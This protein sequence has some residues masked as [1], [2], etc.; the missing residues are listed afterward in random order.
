VQRYTYAGIE[1]LA[2]VSAPRRVPPP[3]KTAARAR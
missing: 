3:T 2:R 1:A